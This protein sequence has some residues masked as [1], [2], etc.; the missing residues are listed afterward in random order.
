LKSTAIEEG[1]NIT[2]WVYEVETG[3]ARKVV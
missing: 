2:G 1:I 3:K